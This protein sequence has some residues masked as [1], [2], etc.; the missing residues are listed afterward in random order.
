VLIVGDTSDAKST[1]VDIVA[2]GGL[3]A[4]DAGSDP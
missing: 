3:L 4:V 1:L 2:A